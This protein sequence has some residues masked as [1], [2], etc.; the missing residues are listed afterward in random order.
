MDKED[1]R[2]SCKTQNTNSMSSVVCCMHLVI[3]GWFDS[4]FGE[5]SIICVTKT[6]CYF[7]MISVEYINICLKN[8]RWKPLVYS[9]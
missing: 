9:M 1:K 8:R 7:K 6:E 2:N 5:E 3:S 4:N